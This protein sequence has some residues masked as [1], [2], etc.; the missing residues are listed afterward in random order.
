VTGYGCE[1][2]NDQEQAPRRLRLH[3]TTILAPRPESFF[4]KRP[5]DE[6]HASWLE[7]TAPFVVLTPGRGLEEAGANLC[8]GDSGG[9]LYREG[10]AVVVGVHAS[11]FDSG[12]VL[13]EDSANVH[14]RVDVESRY[15]IGAWLYWLGVDVRR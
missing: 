6:Q 8:S 10:E 9:A 1:S 5:Q 3:A 12:T 4:P 14:T 13:Y 15:A 2:S 11:T 7:K